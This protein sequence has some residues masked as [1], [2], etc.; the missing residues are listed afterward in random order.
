MEG[1]ALRGGKCQLMLVVTP[2]AAVLFIDGSN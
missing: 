2:A 1:G